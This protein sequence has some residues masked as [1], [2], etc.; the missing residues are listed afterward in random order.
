M[1]RGPSRVLCA[2]NLHAE[3]GEPALL[4]EEGDPF[5]E[6]GAEALILMEVYRDKLSGPR[7]D[8]NARSICR[9]LHERS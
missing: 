5:D 6:S 2:L 4:V 8:L 3:H 7:S 9:R 1:N